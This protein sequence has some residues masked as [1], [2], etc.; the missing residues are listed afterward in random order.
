MIKTAI[1]DLEAH[2]LTIDEKIATIFARTVA[3][4]DSD[5]AELR[6]IQEERLSTQKCL[7]ICA[8]LSDHINQI[9]IRPTE[10][11]HSSP[12]SVDSEPFSE[13][14]TN[15]GLEGCRERLRHTTTTLERHMQLLMDRLMT[16][17]KTT[18][19]SEDEVADLARLRE[20]WNT[21]RQCLH[22]CSEA[23]NRIKENVSLIDNYAKGDETVQFLVS[24][25]DKTIHGK[26]RGFGWRLRQVG[27]HLSDESLQQL[28][29]DISSISNTTARKESP[30]SRGSTSPVADDAVEKGSNSGF[31][32]CHGR[33]VKLMPKSTSQ[34]TE[35]SEL[36]GSPKGQGPVGL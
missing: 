5:A 20:E 18:M 14:V 26:N 27:G 32:E 34:P 13:R 1:D 4:S 8:Q 24:T 31:R 7:Q 3:E 6:S 33:G 15:D 10:R 19:T 9:Q 35:E 16:K 29:R 36:D 11:S 2:L 25:S 21:T 23:E 30:T 28:S 22:I 12:G 17:S